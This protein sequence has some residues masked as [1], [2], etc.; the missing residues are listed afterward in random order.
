M[1]WAPGK[2]APAVCIGSSVVLLALLGAGLR[3]F[4]A[5]LLGSLSCVL[6]S[7]GTSVSCCCCSFSWVAAWP[8]GFGPVRV[9]WG[10]LK[11]GIP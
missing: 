3:H 7:E 4:W 11:F 10:V 8:A 5:L 2:P 6:P 1:A 9:A